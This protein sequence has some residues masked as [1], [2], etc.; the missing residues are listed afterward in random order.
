MNYFFCQEKNLKNINYSPNDLILKDI[1][2][3]FL[4]AEFQFNKKTKAPI[5][6]I[7]LK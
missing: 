2:E 3:L 5:I 4:M 6:R 1:I 7:G